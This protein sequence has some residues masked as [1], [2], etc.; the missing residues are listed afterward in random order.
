MDKIEIPETKFVFSDDA[1][2]NAL[3]DLNKSLAEIA[4]N[5]QVEAFSKVG[6][7]IGAALTGGDV[8]SVFEGFFGFLADGWL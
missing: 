6:E 7:A 5:I 8:G 1:K 4:Q 2:K 3:A